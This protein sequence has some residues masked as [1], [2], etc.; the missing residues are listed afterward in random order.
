MILVTA[1]SANSLTLDTTDHSAQTVAL[2]TI[3]FAVQAGDSF[4]IVPCLTLAAAFGDGSAQNPVFLTG[5]TSVFVSDTIGIYNTIFGIWDA[6]YFDTAKGYWA[7]SGSTA[8]FNNLVL[9]PEA[10]LSITRRAGRPALSFVLE[11]NVPSV[12]PLTKTPGNA[13]LINTSTR[14]PVDLPLSSVVFNGW[15]KGSSG[16]V[17]DTVAIWNPQLASFD[18]YYQRATDSQ[19]RSLKSNTALDQSSL[20]IPAGQGFGLLKR[21]VVQNGSSY[22]SSPLPYAVQP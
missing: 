4:E 20:V 9:Y 3:D 5:G 12:A 8:N 21:A 1:N 14:Y 6:Y 11:G 13:V 15:Q 7:K 2:N 16:F 17:A 19:W 18:S 22:L 10:S